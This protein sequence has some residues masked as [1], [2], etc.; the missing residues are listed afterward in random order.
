MDNI[1][2]DFENIKIPDKLDDTIEKS[3]KRAKK[4]RRI[5]FIRN[6]ST[7]IAV[8]LAVFTLAVNTSSVFA[9]SMMRIPIIKN[10][11]ELVSFDKGLENAVKEGYINT[12]DK[13]AEDK[14]IK[15]TVD[16]IIFD[17]KRLVILYSIETQEP[18]NDIYMRRIE[19]A[20]EKGKRIEGCTLSYGMLS[21]NDNHNLF[22]GSIDV[23]FIENKQIPPIIYLSS[24]M[25]DI[26]H[27]DGD[28][29]T[30]IEGSWKVEIKIPD[31][32]GS[33]SNNYSINRELLIGDI[34]VKIGE[35]KIS[36]T[37]CEINVSFNSDKYKAFRLVNA[38][39]IDERGTVYKNYLSTLSDKNECENKYIFESPFFSKSNHLKLSFD[40][41]YFIPNRDD[42][43]TVDIENNKLIDSSNYGIGLK[44]INKGNNELN[45]GFEITDEEINNNMK[46]YNYVGGIDLGDVYD[47]NGKKCNVASYGYA[48]VNDKESQNIIIKNLYPN[49]KLLKIKIERACK[50][51]MQEVKVDIK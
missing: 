32:S 4:R 51:I 20:D 45:L 30:S 18:Y 36:P 23:H 2:M 37:T 15:V 3:L 33:Q 11:V 5:N 28:N 43:I 34:K 10:I 16:N 49:T 6:L 21:P 35:V 39:I 8:V 25:I 12:I 24:D 17:N 13:S 41:I 27:N 1:K 50:G 29:Y 48:R 19:L 46:R 31:Y 47:E 9:Q 26:K 38:R 7:S 44:Y 22:K 14:G 42:Y 40:G